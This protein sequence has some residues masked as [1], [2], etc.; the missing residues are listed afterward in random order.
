MH[1]EMEINSSE[2]ETDR[3]RWKGEYANEPYVNEAEEAKE[4]NGWIP[5]RILEMP[6]ASLNPAGESPVQ[7]IAEF[8]HKE[9]EEEE[10]EEEWAGEWEDVLNWK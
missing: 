9:E 8:L 4:A 7:H 2:M 6:G 3:N 5:A 10:E 1:S